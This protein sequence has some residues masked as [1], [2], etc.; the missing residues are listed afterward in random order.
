[1]ETERAGHR[2]RESVCVCYTDSWKGIAGVRDEHTRLANS[3]ISHSHT[4][5]E[6]WCSHVDGEEDD[7]N[8]L[9][10]GDADDDEGYGYGDVLAERKDLDF[11]VDA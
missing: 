4:L 10:D 1:M 5:D 9:S 6:S 3:A 8:N 2:E 11:R 7:D